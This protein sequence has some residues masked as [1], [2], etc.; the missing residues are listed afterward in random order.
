MKHDAGWIPE[1]RLVSVGNEFGEVAGGVFT[2]A[3]EDSGDLTKN[4]GAALGLRLRHPG[5]GASDIRWWYASFR[6]RSLRSPRGVTLNEVRTRRQYGLVI[7]FSFALLARSTLPTPPL[8]LLI[9]PHAGA[10]RR[11]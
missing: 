6:A 4:A 3:A 9:P 10:A 2:L 5:C 11:K 8:I 1:S 7:I